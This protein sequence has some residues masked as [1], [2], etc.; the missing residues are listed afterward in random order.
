M[1][2]NPGI[3]SEDFIKKFNTII[4]NSLWK[5]SDKIA[6]LSA[7]NDLKYGGF[8]NTLIL[9]P[10]LKH[11]NWPGLVNVFRKVHC[12]GKLINLLL[13]NFGG[14]LLFR[15]NC[16]PKDC[17]TYSKFDNELLQWCVDFRASFSTNPFTFESIIWNNK[18]IKPIILSKI[19]KRW[20]FILLPSTI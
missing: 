17:K 6:R 16:D 20:N 9:K 15:C 13:K 8:S 11:Q 2:Q 12:L 4:Y 10:Q 1:I 5:G 18:D 7:I 14:K 3:P 19:C